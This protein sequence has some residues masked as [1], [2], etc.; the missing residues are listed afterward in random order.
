MH[1]SRCLTRRRLLT[2][3]GAAAS[4]LLLSTAPRPLFAT[5][6]Q[7]TVRIGETEIT[8]LSDGIFTLPLSFVLPEKPRGEAEA[9]LASHGAKPEFI[10]ETNVILIRS[11]RLLALVD[12]GGGT[13]F[14]PTLGRLPDA[15]DAMG[16]KAED[17]THVIFTHAHADHF[18]GVTDPF[19]EES[20]WPNA[21]HIMGIAER[22]FWLANDVENRVPEALKGMA[23]G[24][25]RRLRALGDVITT[26]QDGAEIAPGIALL[27]TPGHTPGHAAIVVRAG[28]TELIIG[29]DALTHAVVSFTEPT[30][31][32]GSDLDWQQAA[33]TRSR[34]LDRL[35]SSKAMLAGY[36]LPWPGLGRVERN[37][38]SYRFVPQT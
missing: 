20:R 34:L 1:F 33:S 24:I 21:R 26:A 37:G 4:G 3:A 6:R 29:G 36:H 14:M 32:W 12:T 38:T 9:Y 16:V 17:V 28:G 31:R 5:T 27:G 8:A 19:T 22:D 13:D 18:W 23:I 35:A 30:W 15:L 10:G 2:G 25:K 11:G 7:H